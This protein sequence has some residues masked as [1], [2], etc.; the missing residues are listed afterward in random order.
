MYTMKKYRLIFALLLSL[1]GASETRSQTKHWDMKT[2]P[3]MTKWAKLV[4][5]KNTLPEY[6]RPQLERKEW[7]NLNGIWEF[8]AG[9]SDDILPKEKK[10][11]KQILVP[12]PVESALSG[13]M[14][15]HDRLWY[16]KVF[17]VPRNWAGKNIRIN[18]GAVDWESEVFING[19]SVGTHKGG[20]GNFSYDITKYLV[21]GE[22]EVIVRVFDPTDAYGQP[23]GKQTSSPVG[24]MYTPT[25]GIWQSVWI[26]PVSKIS[27]SDL[28]IIPDIDAKTVK[29]AVNTQSPKKGL[30]VLIKTKDGNT[31][32]AEARGGVNLAL[33]IPIKKPKLWSAGNPFLYDLEITLLD[34]NEKVDQVKSYFGMRK[35]SIVEDGGFKKIFLNNK[36]LYQMGVLDQGFWP[37]GI[38]TAPTDDALKCDIEQAKAMGFNLIRKHIKVESQRWYYWA[39]KLGMLVWQDMPSANS[40]LPGEVSPPVVD[41][42]AY[43]TE[44]VEMMDQLKNTPSI[45]VWVLFNESQGQH[46]TESLVKLIREKD[47]TRL[48]NE[49]SGDKF[50]GFGDLID[51]HNYPPPRAPQSKTHA[52]VIGEFGGIGY[53]FGSHTWAKKGEGYTNAVDVADLVFLYSEYVDKL[54]DYR[55]KTGL[56]ASIYTQLTDVETETNGLLTYDRL[57][58]YDLKGIKRLNTFNFPKPQYRPLLPTAEVEP[59][60]WK[61]VLAQPGGDWKSKSYGDTAWNEGKGGFGKMRNF[62]KTAWT[63]QDIWLRKHFNPGVLTVE[64]INS[65]VIRILYD[66]EVEIYINGVS[67]FT[68]RG[69]RVEYENRSLSREAKA[70]LV[71]NGDNIISIHARKRNNQFIDVGLYL[72][73]L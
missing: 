48:I 19:R 45:I 67:A 23:R 40:Y 24:I 72:K 21:N 1:L 71:S 29:I 63:T 39:D 57:P 62:G 18:F 66:R 4:N 38:Y 44:L 56:N 68:D 12:F 9:K 5:P 61:Y 25:T 37:D 27:I 32:V 58:K 55:D 15:H 47:S 54:R 52:N 51:L 60:S 65:L 73:L 46:D 34:G 7:L 53:R 16:R 17:K 14:E 2:A 26:E 69:S 6:P 35:I 10:L 31:Q 70:A 50:Y 49:A 13:V 3:L 30:M 59:Q 28:T 41:K 8:Q 64:Q 22:Q 43:K 11:D 20:Y 36:F 42:V 33:I